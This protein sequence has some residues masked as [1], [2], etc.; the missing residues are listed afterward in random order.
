L[1][2]KTHTT[3]RFEGKKATRGE[4][5]KR[6]G[7]VEWKDTTWRGR[8]TSSLSFGQWNGVGKWGKMNMK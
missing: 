7:M 3:E 2:W 1:K 6:K 4:E 8:E 5:K